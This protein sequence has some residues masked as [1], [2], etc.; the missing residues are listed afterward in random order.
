[1]H[2]RASIENKAKRL[3]ESGGTGNN[4][5]NATIYRLQYIFYWPT[6]KPFAV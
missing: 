3:K 1:M 6:S 5:D 2:G 4:N